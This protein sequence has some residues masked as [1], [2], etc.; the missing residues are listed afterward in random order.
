ML[1]VRA[2]STPISN[3]NVVLVQ[4]VHHEML[5]DSLP[6][7]WLSG[8]LWLPQMSS[9]TA[10]AVM[11]FHFRYYLPDHQTPYVHAGMTVLRIQMFKEKLLRFH[12]LLC[13]STATRSPSSV[14]KFFQPHW[15][16][17][18]EICYTPLPVLLQLCQRMSWPT[19]IA[20]YWPP[21]FRGDGQFPQHHHH[22]WS[23]HFNLLIWMLCE[24]ESHNSL[25][26]PPGE[27]KIMGRGNKK[28]ECLSPDVISLSS[29]K[30]FG[31][32]NR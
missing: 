5:V 12:A 14:L 2:H 6:A 19:G 25:V 23:L 32:C 17:R 11:Y 8:V 30:Q 26:R 13:S 31:Y 21:A 22:D 7:I 1:L 24:W 18:S 20:P 27:G 3:K 4:A 29:S 9:V 28:K 16:I 15:S 10:T